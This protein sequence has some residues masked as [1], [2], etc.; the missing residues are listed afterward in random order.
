MND[1]T[2]PPAIVRPAS[3]LAELAAQISDQHRLCVEATSTAL[4]HAR[5]AGE[6]L[7]AAKERAGH[8]QWLPWLKANCPFSERT[9]QGYMRVAREWPRLQSNPQRVA[10]LSYRD[11]LRLLAESMEGEPPRVPMPALRPGMCYVAWSQAPLV[12]EEPVYVAMEIVPTEQ[13]GYWRYGFLELTMPP[14]PGAEDEADGW[15]VTNVRGVALNRPHVWASITRE[16]GF[17]GQ[18]EE[19]P[20]SQRDFLIPDLTDEQARAIRRAQILGE[21]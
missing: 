8:G 7:V 19:S 10:D 5:R 13:E 16:F 18:W 14:P 6:L 4:E 21:D 20:K 11:A 3:D 2:N 17:A 9:A 12:P 1:L 15:V